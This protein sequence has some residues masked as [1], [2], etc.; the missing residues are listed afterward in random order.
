MSSKRNPAM[1]A[2]VHARATETAV[3]L[4]STETSVVREACEPGDGLPVNSSARGHCCPVQARR[5][6]ALFP[7]DAPDVQADA[8]NCMHPGVLH[9]CQVLLVVGPGL[10]DVKN[11]VPQDEVILIHIGSCGGLLQHAE[12]VVRRQV[13]GSD[14]DSAAIGLPPESGLNHASRHDNLM[15]VDA[16]GRGDDNGDP[17]LPVM[18]PGCTGRGGDDGRSRKRIGPGDAVGNG[19]V[20]LV[21]N[22]S[23]LFE[24]QIGHNFLVSEMTRDL[25]L[26]SHWMFQRANRSGPMCEPLINAFRRVK[27]RETTEKG[28]PCDPDRRGPRV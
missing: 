1:A 8:T 5:L 28:C 6:L 10:L 22:K 25:A 7:G 9:C 3:V 4:C 21:Q 24:N 12:P 27:E 23:L 14:E 16:E 26:T 15:A 18:L 13:D 20:G 11:K 2:A 17:A 19:P